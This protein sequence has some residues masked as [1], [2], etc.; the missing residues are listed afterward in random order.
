MNSIRGLEYKDIKII[1]ENM[2]SVKQRVLI[3]C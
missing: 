1:V 3:E 2:S